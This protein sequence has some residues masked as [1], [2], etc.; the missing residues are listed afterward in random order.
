L[1]GLVIGLVEVGDNDGGLDGLLAGWFEGLVVGLVD[2]GDCV[3]SYVGAVVGEPVSILGDEVG[4]LDGPMVGVDVGNTAL[5]GVSVG[6]SEGVA[7]GLTAA[8]G[9]MVGGHATTPS[10]HHPVL[11]CINVPYNISQHSSSS[12]VTSHRYLTRSPHG[13]GPIQSWTHRV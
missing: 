10:A 9:A 4:T 1:E 5:N 11:D 7:D 8:A 2:S 13:G 3:G 6:F 12:Y